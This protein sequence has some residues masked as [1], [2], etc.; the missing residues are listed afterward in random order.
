MTR[1]SIRAATLLVAATLGVGFANG[2]SVAQGMPE[3]ATE[4]SKSKSVLVGQE[5]VIGVL[6]KRTGNTAE[7]ALKP[8]DH[9]E[10]GRISGVLRA[11]EAT[12]PWEE[13]QTAAFLQVTATTAQLRKKT[14]AKPKQIFSGWLFLEAPS[15]NPFVHPVYDV[16][17]KSCTI[18]SPDGP[19]SAKNSGAKVTTGATSKRASGGASQEAE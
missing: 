1:A 12:A 15:L 4:P 2:V 17:L 7:F 14:E 5:A 13:P 8:D 19:R 10:W 6:N 3:A 18:K 11:C 9:F 16:W